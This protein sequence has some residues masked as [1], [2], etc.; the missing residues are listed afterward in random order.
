MEENFQILK[1]STNQ[2]GKAFDIIRLPAGPLMTKKVAYKS[3][4]EAEQSWFDNV[5]TDSV[6]FYLA[7]GYMNFI[8]ANKVIITA[9]FW[10]GGLPNEFKDRDELAKQILEKA[11]LGRKIVQIDCMP[12][13]HDGGGIHCHSRN[14]PKG[15]MMITQ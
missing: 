9:K 5:T 3:L 11:F 10:K 6:E 1:Q 7:T 12:L 4:T 8:I 15:K 2:D 13:H 14:Q